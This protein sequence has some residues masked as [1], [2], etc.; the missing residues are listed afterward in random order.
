MHLKFVELFCDVV[1]YRSF[2]K[3][4]AAHNVSQSAASQAVNLLEKHLETKLIDRSVR[5][6]ELTPAGEVYYEGCREIVESVH[7]LEDRIH[8]LRDKVAGVVHVA[9]IYSVGFLQMDAY[10][11]GFSERYRDAKVRVEYRHPEEVYQEVLDGEADLGLVSFPRDRGEIV[12]R[13][14]QDQPMVLVVHPQHKFAREISIS[15]K[16]LDGEPFVGFTSDL[17]IR[18]EIDRWLKKSRV[19]VQIVHEFDNI[20]NIKRAIEV[21]TGGAILPQP[22]IE[23][24]VRS[25][26]LVAIPFSDVQWLRPLGVIHKRQEHLSNATQKFIEYLL[27]QCPT[28]VGDVLP[29]GNEQNRK[30]EGSATRTV[31]GAN[32]EGKSKSIEETSDAAAS[33]SSDTGTAD[34][35]GNSRRK[36][37]QTHLI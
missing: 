9:A 24:E 30:H 32:P 16:R 37:R 18:K 12:S 1:Q 5:P 33:P 7:S 27:S 17:T 21:G 25:G 29:T 6:F 8:K 13:P 34:G 36:K 10:I 35:E 31:S 23:R 15:V 2:S 28:C 4:A 3:A 22:T 11:K 20:E 19:S 26:S 14:W